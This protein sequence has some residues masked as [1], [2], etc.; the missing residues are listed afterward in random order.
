[1]HTGVFEKVTI[2]GAS[3]EG[4]RAFTER[5]E[6]DLSADITILVGSNGTGKTS[7]LDALLWGITGRLKRVGDGNERVLSLYAPAGLARVSLELTDKNGRMSL[8]RTLLEG[9][10]SLA[11]KAGD[12]TIEGPAADVELVRRLWDS[13]SSSATP[14]D[15]LHDVMTRS[16]Y[17]QQDL[18]RQFVDRDSAPERFDAIGS[19]I[20]VGRIADFQRKLVSSRKAWATV[21]GQ[22]E[23]GLA[24]ADRRLFSIRTDL[25]RLGRDA[26]ESDA[27]MH[28]TAWWN[29]LLD[30]GLGIR[31]IPDVTMPNAAQVLEQMLRAL[32]TARAS[33]QRKLSTL[34]QIRAD[35]I[36]LVD[37]V[38]IPDDEI[39]R[40]RGA[41][42]S[43]RAVCKNLEK[44]VAAAEERDAAAR[45]DLLAQKNAADEMR[46]LANLALRH[47]SKHCPVCD[48][49][50][51]AKAVER[52]LKQLIGA[53]SSKRRDVLG[54]SP[55]LVAELDRASRDAKK[56]ERDLEDA[57]NADKLIASRR[58]LLKSQLA[59]IELEVA[60]VEALD[61]LASS[62]N[63][64]ATDL[65]EAYK[66]G[67]V[68][69]LA[70]VRLS[71][72]GKRGDLIQQE[73]SAIEMVERA[74]V[75]LEDYKTAHDEA[76]RIIEA[77][78]EVSDEAVNRQI[79]RIGPLLQKIYTRIDPHP[80][81]RIAELRSYVSY[82]KGRVETPVT[83]PRSGSG[84]I[85]VDSPADIFSS[86][87]TNALAVSIFL[88]MNLASDGMPLQT[89][90]LDDPLQSLDVI[91]L[92]GLLDVLRRTRERRQL[93]ISTHDEN[94]AALLRRKFRPVEEG[95][96]T[97]L[98]TLRNWERSGVNL[99]Q[100][101]E[102]DIPAR[103]QVV[104]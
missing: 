49:S 94:F 42:T 50:I 101:T 59:D 99:E 43:A 61:K 37:A 60:D 55:K 11:L 17:L 46:A 32:Q 76:S 92:L 44:L 72:E 28:W 68:L 14:L 84:K 57:L 47:L 24:E 87:Q 66:S 23:G 89:A 75:V 100:S 79:D 27:A 74:R 40:L 56:V 97:S 16:V 88:A 70:I 86:S 54:E 73:S 83:D 8:V 58:T 104:S 45:A 36:Q 1:M 6:V 85:E 26:R 95:Q 67:E 81:F 51:D 25:A 63:T 2:L 93:L 3:I 71:E 31:P 90:I 77:V 102:T 103:L 39:Q 48:Q 80:T 21:M 18:V 19:L 96:R 22:K 52:R 15:D 98:I 13:G 33:I 30:K 82:G 10:T 29:G 41:V 20:G 12:R 62:L 5:V 9:Q 34:P 35:I 69:A 38:E 78:R 91:N 7:L 64:Q 4:F 65:A 53:E